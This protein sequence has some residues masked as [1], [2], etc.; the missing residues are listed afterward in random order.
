MKNKTAQGMINFINSCP[1]P[2]H[3][4]EEV[5]KILSEDGFSE[6]KESDSWKLWKGMKGYVK[7]NDSS[8]IA[9]KI[10]ST[11]EIKGYKIFLAHSD[12]PAFKLKE[13]PEL[14]DEFGVVRL[15]TEKYGGMILS[16]WFDRP[17]SVAGRVIVEKEGKLK[18]ILVNIDRDLLVIPNV[19][20]HMNGELN[21]G[22][23]YKAQSDLLPVFKASSTKDTLM[24]LVA[25]SAG[26]KEDE[27]LGSDL[28]LYT[29]QKG[30]FLGPKDE[31]VLCPRLDDQACAYGGLMGFT[32]PDS[33][34]EDYEESGYISVYCVYDNEEVGSQ[35][36]RGAG[37]TFLEDVLFRVAES[38]SLSRTD[39]L[40]LLSSS[41]AIS[42]DNAHGVHPAMPSKADIVNRPVL[43]GGVVLKF[44][45]N[46]HYTTDG[47][48]A[49]KVR[50]LA[51]KADI[52]L[53]DFVNNSD[54]RGGST[55]GNISTSQVSIN[56][57]DIGLA[58]YSMH[59]STETMGAMDI[60]QLIKL[61]SAL[62][63]NE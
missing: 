25:K 24:A 54:V 34:A 58:Q 14:K 1:T 27:I 12:S 8:I 3:V 42:A 62:Y 33:G 19:A 9:F 61:A 51:R 47:L 40:R 5:S 52:V 6:Y 39:Y 49:A 13:K 28:Y 57:A 21:S 23:T 20:I 48:S 44:N 53:Q 15:N 46:Q 32:A 35:T 11:K 36:M 59:S 43:N 10:P 30:T 56:T 37:S 16:T 50:S 38:L 63:M 22:Y 31:F 45:A 26:V 41:F 17:L 7:R 2:F 60:E 55:L 18:S 4:I 29:R